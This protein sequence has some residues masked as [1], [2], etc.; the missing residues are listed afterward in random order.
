LSVKSTDSTKST[1][2]TKQLLFAGAERELS[3]KEGKIPMD[4]VEEVV[5]DEL[6]EE[7]KKNLAEPNY[8]SCCLLSQPLTKLEKEPFTAL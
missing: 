2:L 7:L 4:L 8:C 6:R 5:D 3:S 1:R